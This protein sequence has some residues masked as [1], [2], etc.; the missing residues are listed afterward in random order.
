MNLVINED[1]LRNSEVQEFSTKV[2][3]ILVDEDNQILISNYGNIILLPGGKVDKDESIFDAITRELKEELGVYYK[4]DELELFEILSYYQKNYPKV[5]GTI[6]N[7]LVK[8]YYFIGPYK[9]I[10]KELQ[11]LSDREKKANFKLE[12]VSLD[13]LENIILSNK[14]SNPRNIYFQKEL[15][16]ILSSYNNN[17]KKKLENKISNFF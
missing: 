12:L 1:N 7:R 13:E 15:L 5:D 11:K 6:Q 16:F 14:N 2:R 10:K 4:S 3:A 8:T 17:I 9:G